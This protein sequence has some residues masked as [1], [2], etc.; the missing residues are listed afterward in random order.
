MNRLESLPD[1]LQEKIYKCAHYLKFKDTLTEIEKIDFWYRNSMI[2]SIN[3][4]T[5]LLYV[6]GAT[7]E[8]R[9]EYFMCMDWLYGRKFNITFEELEH[10]LY[11]NI[12]YEYQTIA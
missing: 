1:E 11:Y 3:T 9:E 6:F 10:N 2:H 5:N 4:M 8:E 7:R 12:Y